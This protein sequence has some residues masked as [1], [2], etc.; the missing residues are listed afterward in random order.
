MIK[1][2]V[3]LIDNKELSCKPLLAA[4]KRKAAGIGYYLRMGK[5]VKELL[6]AIDFPVA[7]NRQY[8]TQSSID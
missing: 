4:Q 7:V 6:L 2:Q 5:L 8:L 3:N 1:L